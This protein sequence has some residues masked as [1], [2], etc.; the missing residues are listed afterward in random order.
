M[1]ARGWGIEKG[2]VA[3]QPEQFQSQDEKVLEIS[4]TTNG[5]TVNNLFTR[6]DFMLTGLYYNF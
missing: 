4:Y 3:I 2:E 1:V 6:V 5:H